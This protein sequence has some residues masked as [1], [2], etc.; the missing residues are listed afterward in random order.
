MTRD[1]GMSA[2]VDPL[3]CSFTPYVQCD[4]SE[5]SFYANEFSKVTRAGR[6]SV[7]IGSH[8]LGV[9]LTFINIQTNYLWLQRVQEGGYFATWE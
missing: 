6:V 3:C 8:Q 2:C 7:L 5:M 4:A 9:T 1:R